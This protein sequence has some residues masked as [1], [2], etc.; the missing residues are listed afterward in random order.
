MFLDDDK[1]KRDKPPSGGGDDG[2]QNWNSRCNDRNAMSLDGR[3]NEN[4]TKQNKIGKKKRGIF[5]Y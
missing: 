4:I 3:E 5:E 1:G 2:E